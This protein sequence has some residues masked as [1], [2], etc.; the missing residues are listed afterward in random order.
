MNLL[1]RTITKNKL[2][3]ALKNR[4]QHLAEIMDSKRRTDLLEN[5]TAYEKSTLPVFIP[6]NMMF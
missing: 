2:A 6:L 3:S 5:I 1:Q 4:S